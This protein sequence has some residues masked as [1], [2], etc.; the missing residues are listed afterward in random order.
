MESL[1]EVTGAMAANAAC[2]MDEE[3]EL[4]SAGMPTYMLEAVWW[5]YIERATDRFLAAL[6]GI[7]NEHSRTGSLGE[8]VYAALSASLVEFE[9][10]ARMFERSGVSEEI[11]GLARKRYHERTREAFGGSYFVNRTR[12]WPRGYHGDYLTIEGMYRN[13]PL[14]EGMGMLIDRYFLETR[15]P[16]AVRGRMSTLRDMLAEELAKGAPLSILDIASGPCRELAEL[17]APITA[18]GSRVTCLDIDDEALGFAHSRLSALGLGEEH[19]TLKK[20]NAVKLVNVERSLREFGPQDFIYSLGLFD[21]LSDRTIST[22]LRS[23]HA[24]LK[25]GGRLVVAFPDIERYSTIEFNWFIDWQILHRTRNES[26]RII[27]EAGIP[28]GLVAETRE[29]SG[30]IVLYT[31]T[32]E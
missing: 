19:V 26:R 23:L 7:Y 3:T 24:M 17:A 12:T 25:P 30:V 21:Y 8:D 32:K 22:M 6:K 16:V 9:I 1:A 4:E 2:V 18:S 20:H 11:I 29:P 27:A 5:D 15:L 31:I 10:S 13:T 28:D 14:S